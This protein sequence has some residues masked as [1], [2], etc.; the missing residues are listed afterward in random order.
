M[1]ATELSGLAA[2]YEAYRAELRRFLVA[3]TGS[4][5][6]ADD[7]MQELWLRIADARSGPIA[8]PKSYLYRMAQNLVLDRRRAGLRRA[9]RERE[10]ADVALDQHPDRPEPAANSPEAEAIDA[11]FAEQV[12]AAVASLPPGAQRA[13]RMHKLDGL[14]HA[15]TAAALGISRKGVEKHMATAFAHLRRALGGEVG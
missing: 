1:S 13:F 14:S 6:E 3:R 4:P 8:S 5:A 7:V 2:A 10:W 15:E 9:E 11:E 12:A